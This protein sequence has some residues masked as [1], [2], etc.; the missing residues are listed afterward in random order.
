L[1]RFFFHDFSPIKGSKIDEQIKPILAL[2]V[3]P[4]EQKRALPEALKGN[5]KARDKNPC[6]TDLKTLYL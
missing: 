3:K 6:N 4:K 1:A 5:V 2:H